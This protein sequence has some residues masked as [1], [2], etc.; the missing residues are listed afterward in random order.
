[1]I[2]IDMKRKIITFDELMS[3]NFDELSEFIEN[4]KKLIEEGVYSNEGTNIDFMGMTNEEI[5]KKYGFTEKNEFFNN[6][7]ERLFNGK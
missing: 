4:D 2:F 7:R 3:M 1:M 6:L 5:I